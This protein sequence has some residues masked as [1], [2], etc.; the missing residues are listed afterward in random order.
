MS[1]CMKLPMVSYTLTVED[2]HL[3]VQS[4]LKSQHKW[5]QEVSS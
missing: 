5:L 1:I 2:L 4:S 3:Q